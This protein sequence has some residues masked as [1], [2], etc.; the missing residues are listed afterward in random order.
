MA[1]KGR[2]GKTGESW[3][4]PWRKQALQLAESTHFTLNEVEALRELFELV[5]T[6]EHT[7]H[8]PGCFA[9]WLSNAP[10]NV[11][12]LHR[13]AF[14][15]ALFGQRDAFP[16]LFGDRVFALFDHSNEGSIT[17]PECAA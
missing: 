16:H 5:S 2:R 9:C 4:K 12:V 15:E 17:F 6:E 1:D 10:R 7:H 8:E 13:E 11:R 14:M 3:A